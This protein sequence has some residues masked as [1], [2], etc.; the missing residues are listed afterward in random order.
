MTSPM[1]KDAKWVR[2]SFLVKS[3]DLLPLDQQNRNFS[4][5]SMKFVDTTPGGNFCINPPPQFTRYADL[6]VKSKYPESKG[7]GRYYSEAIDDNNQIIH[8]RM[9]V[10]AFNSLSNFFTGFYD[11]QVG[12]LAR[13]GRIDKAFFLLGRAAGMVVQ[14]IFWPLLA[15]QLL[16]A[17]LKFAMQKPSSKFYY[18]KPAMPLYWNAVQT[19]V[20]QIAV[21]RGVVPRLGGGGPQQLGGPYEFSKD[22]LA[23]MHSLLPDIFK[24]GGGIDVYAMANRAQRLAHQRHRRMQQELEASQPTT[25]F[26]TLVNGVD[27]VLTRI[28]VTFEK[29]IDKW[30]AAEP[31]Q[32][33]VDGTVEAAL[34][35]GEDPPGFF[36]FFEAEMYEGGAFASFRV[37][38]TGSVNENFASQVTES[39]ISSKFNGMSAQGREGM[40]NFAHGNI[41]DGVAGKIVGAVLGSVQSLVQG[42]LSQVGLGGLAALGGAAFADI[43]QHWQSSSA[44]FARSTYTIHLNSWA[45]N[46]I[47]HMLNIYIP[48]AMI[49]A[50]GLPLS[51]GKQSY[52]SPFLV[53]LY[54]QGR[55]QTRLGLV[56][57]I[58]ITRGTGNLGFDNQ[59]H[60]MGIDVSFSIMDM[61]KIMHMPIAE[62]LSP[63]A[64]V[65]AAAGANVAKAATAI[66]GEGSK[67]EAVGAV[68]GGV[69]GGAFFDDDTSFTDYMAT[70][71]SLGLADQIYS[72]RKL[73][74]NL[75]M[76]AK[77]WDSWASWSHFASV[78]ADWAPVRLWASQYRGTA[79]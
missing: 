32:P 71:G 77:Q 39:E 11:A 61:S 7:M 5:A 58:S 20:N 73:K 75:T 30:I 21:N 26:Q 74:M 44:Q 79:K 18:S 46:P 27:K 38:S 63:L 59:G 54:D 72:L 76:R 68:V 28:P 8:L 69:L 35:E 57:S 1:L 52:T 29:Y 6:K 14:V 16:G 4:T 3:S 10:P 49:L 47:S 62:G 45:G 41:D 13:T 56:D 43:P 60:A 64:G 9:G 34:K 53:E 78:S 15:V 37:N 12:Q 25:V 40:F 23:K 24:E 65:A 22:A 31:S 55:C 66:G 70:L 33:K 42:T 48:L 67:T 36:S 51:T 50:T 2:Q 19:I 17:G